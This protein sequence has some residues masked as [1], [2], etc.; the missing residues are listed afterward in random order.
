MCAL[1]INQPNREHIH[2]STEFI[3]KANIRFNGCKEQ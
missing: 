1:A 3:T 2:V